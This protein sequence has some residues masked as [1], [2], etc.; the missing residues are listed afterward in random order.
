MCNTVIDN[1]NKTDKHSLITNLLNFLDTD[2]VLY[3]SDVSNEFSI[4]R[5]IENNLFLINFYILVHKEDNELYKLQLKEWMPILDWFNEKFQ[6]NI[7]PVR[8][9]SFSCCS[10]DVKQIFEHYLN[11]YSFP[12]LHGKKNLKF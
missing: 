11:S 7:N 12:C 6:T 2:T 4:K 8:G 3:Y 10:E 9:I 1:P 5:Y